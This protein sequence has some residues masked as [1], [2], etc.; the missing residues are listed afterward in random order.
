MLRLVCDLRALQFSQINNRLGAEYVKVAL[1]QRGM[2]A[3][4]S[5]SPGVAVEHAA[6]GKS[7]KYLFLPLSRIGLP[8]NPWRRKHLDQ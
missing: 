5:A 7:A 2:N 3:T 4:V 8:F 6:A 1:L